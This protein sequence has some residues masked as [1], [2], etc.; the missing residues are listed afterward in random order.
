MNNNT[1]LNTKDLFIM[2]RGTSVVTYQSLQFKQIHRV[3][4]WSQTQARQGLENSDWSMPEQIER[5]RNE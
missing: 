5:S 3:V 2:Y 4:H 1:E